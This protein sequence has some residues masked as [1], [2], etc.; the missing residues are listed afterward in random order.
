MYKLVG[1]VAHLG[2]GENY[3]HYISYIKIG[4]YVL[5]KTN[6][7]TCLTMTKLQKQTIICFSL[8]GATRE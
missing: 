3:G 4:T 1:V 2:Q 8:F 5:I 7:G 6:N